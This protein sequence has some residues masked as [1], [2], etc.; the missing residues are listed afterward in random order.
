MKN[1]CYVL[2]LFLI[3]SCNGQGK[4]VLKGESEFQ[5]EMN[6]DFKD[7]SKSPLTKKGLKNFKGLDFYPIDSKYTIE[8]KQ[9]VG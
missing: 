5:Q 3:M 1:S 8:A 7:A 4:R 9:Q 6:A 2:F